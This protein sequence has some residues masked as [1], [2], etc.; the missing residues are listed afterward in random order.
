M[1]KVFFFLLA[2]NFLFAAIL[3]FHKPGSH[4]PASASQVVNPEKIISLPATID[5]TEWGPFPESQIATAQ[6]AIDTLSLDT[7]HR[8]IMSNTLTQFKVHTKP[9]G[10][11]QIAEREI[12]KLRNMGIVSYRILDQGALFNAIFFGEFSDQASAQNYKKN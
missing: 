4:A 9:F 12:N 3:F 10:N 8:Q 2:V 11:R 1:K 6:E 5:C 7:P